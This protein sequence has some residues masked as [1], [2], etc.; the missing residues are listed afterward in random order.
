MNI[1]VDYG[2]TAAKVGI[3]TQGRLDRKL[4]FGSASELRSFLEETIPEHLI[5]SSVAIP[6]KDIASWSASKGKKIILSNQ[7]PVPIRL[8]YRTPETLGVD[9]IAAVCGALDQLPDTDCLVIDA[10]TCITF[11]F[12]DATGTYHGG[13]ISPGISMRFEA[14]HQF[15]SRL[16]LVKP[17]LHP[18]LIG[19]STETS[20]QSG[21]I[22]GARAEVNGIL[23]SYRKE[24]PSIQCIVCGGDADYL[25]EEADPSRIIVPDLVL[26]GL[27]RIL[28]HSLT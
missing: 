25:K 20:L 4:I 19:D 1:A 18:A 7:T 13:A 2:N 14:M 22:N 16:P 24:Y 26:I 21:A 11:E 23:W 27:N 17:V 5:V 28:L 12:L 3:F 6:A 10:G 8:K 15:T 9:R